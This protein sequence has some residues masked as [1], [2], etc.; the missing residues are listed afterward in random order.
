MPLPWVRLDAN[1]ASHDKILYLLAQRDGSKA[2]VLYVCALGYAGGH[3]TDG[4]IPAYALPVIHGSAK[5][6][7]LLVDCRLWT[8]NG[9]GGYVIRNWEQRQQSAA[10]TE[11]VS[12]QQSRG[13]RKGNCIRHHGPRCGCWQNDT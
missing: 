9:D 2:F 12:E 4:H 3:G 6:A 5:L 1:I 8:H 7:R 13:G 11:W 10:T